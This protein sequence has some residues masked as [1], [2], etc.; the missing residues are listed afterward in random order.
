MRTPAIPVTNRVADVGSGTLGTTPA[1]AGV[2]MPAN[3]VVA[4]ATRR[5]L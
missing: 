5:L 4:L 3:K 2:A 1:I